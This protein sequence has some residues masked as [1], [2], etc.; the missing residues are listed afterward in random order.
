MHSFDRLSTTE[1][2]VWLKH[3]VL[4]TPKEQEASQDP[5][6][7]PLVGCL[8]IKNTHPQK[9]QIITGLHPHATVTR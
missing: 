9:G 5:G 1:A 4:V 7:N 8:P 6:Q 2:W 3:Q